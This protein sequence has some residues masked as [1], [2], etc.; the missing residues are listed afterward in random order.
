MEALLQTN[1]RKNV[2]IIGA[3]SGIGRELAKVFSD[4]GYAVGITARRL[5]MLS[6]VKKELP[7]TSFVKR[8]DVAVPEA[9]I[10]ILEE[11]IKEMGGMDIIVINAGIGFI[12]PELQWEKEKNTIDVNVTGF[13]AMANVAMRY[14]I[15]QGSGHIVGISSIAALRG[16]SS[17]PAYNASKA[18]MSNYLEA[19][20]SRAKKSKVAITVTDIQPGFVNTAMAQG[21][22]LFWVAS[23][24]KAAVQIF[25]VI[26]KK[27]SHAYI[28]KRW[29]FI[30]WL[31]KILPWQILAKL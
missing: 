9:A 22:R 12:N 27:R 2:I 31:F 20:R 17:A 21:Q 1:T 11:L 30:A 3:S 24:K 14:F 26:K 13:A 8:V 10:S 23:A 7:G 15:R 28:T 6:D 29:R 25:E 5:E 16:G 19:L 4:N 18:F